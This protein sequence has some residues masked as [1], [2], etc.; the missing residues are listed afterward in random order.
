MSIKTDGREWFHSISPD[1]LEEDLR[2][3]SGQ[4]QASGV[5][6]EDS[7]EVPFLP[8][9]YVY[10]SEKHNELAK[11]FELLTRIVNRL[12]DLYTAEKA[13]RDYHAL[14][15][16]LHGIM[17]PPPY[18]PAVYYCRYDFTFDAKGAPRIY[19]INTAGPAGVVFTHFQRLAFGMT[20]ASR[21]LSKILP[22]RHED[23]FY[24]PRF[25]AKELIANASRFF[26]RRPEGIGLINSKYNTLNNELSLLE[27]DFR[28]EKIP[29]VRG[30]VEDLSYRPD[31]TP[32]LHGI[33]FDAAYHK[34]YPRFNP[35]FEVPFSRTRAEVAPYIAALSSG[36]LFGVNSLT[37]FYGMESKGWLAFMSDPDNARF[38]S[39]AEKELIGKMVP[40]TRY[41]R[42]LSVA[43][44][45]KISNNKDNFIIKKCIETRGTG[46][47]TGKDMPQG[48]WDAKLKETF[49]SGE[50]VVQQFEPPEIFEYPGASPFRKGSTV[51]INHACYVIQ[52]TARG[53]ITRIS[54]KSV[55]NVGSGGMILPTVVSDPR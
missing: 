14:P 39:E 6:F 32:M 19:E 21:E 23:P 11:S 49:S 13:V 25:F 37:S 47:F 35:E 22:V 41:L 33:P 16:S 7:R 36:K 24:S 42:R 53:L 5:L 46:I 51:Y 26:G 52:E 40:Y 2:L 20:K 18:R 15:Q 55:T 45:E 3:C 10:S 30:H 29:V 17:P 34:F 27:K 44:L 50:H 8:L 4:M 28:E 12:P 38:F 48:E 31:G 9:P 43:E 54:S 1:S